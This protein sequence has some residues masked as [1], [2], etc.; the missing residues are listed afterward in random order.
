MT[1]PGVRARLLWW[2]VSAVACLVVLTVTQGSPVGMTRPWA[3]GSWAAALERD[4]PVVTAMAVARLL[5]LGLAWYVVVVTLLVAAGGRWRGSRSERLVSWTCVGPMRRWVLALTG[6]AVV[7]PA[8]G[9]SVV[10]PGS[11]PAMAVGVTAEGADATDPVTMR[12]VEPDG[13]GLPAPE[14][15]EPPPAAAEHVPDG[16]VPDGHVV[17]AGESFWSIAADVV[18]RARG[19]VPCDSEVAGYWLELIEVNRHHLVD[20]DNPDLIFPGQVFRLPPVA[21]G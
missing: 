9:A 4:G 19:A 15:D 5:A 10:A 20:R 8:L 2:W 16:H 13:E 12:L 1:P 7:G 14:A 3:W 6:A 17:T 18:T 21:G 11:A